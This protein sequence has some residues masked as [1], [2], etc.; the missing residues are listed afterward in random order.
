MTNHYEATKYRAEVAVRERLA[1]GLPATIYRPAITVGDSETGET[2]KYDG[3]YYLLRLLAAQPRLLS[4][5]PRVPGAA[6]TELNVVP[7]DYVV[8]AVAHLSG[9]ADT[10][11]ETY[12]LCDPAPL[13]VPRFVSALGDALDHRVVSVPLPKR[14]VKGG[15]AALDQRG[16]SAEP[17]TLDYFDHPTRYANPQTQ[18]ALAGTGIDC[19]RIESY[20]D[21]LVAYVRDNPAVGDDAMI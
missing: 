14:V 2:D 7:R 9:R 6:R 12:Q 20:L 5:A 19:P 1:D 8:D 17:A 13:T 16:I 18:R 3:P 11:G 21:R 15:M 4:L 10:V